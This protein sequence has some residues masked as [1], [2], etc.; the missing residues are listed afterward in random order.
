M[1]ETKS[2]HMVES[3]SE[4]MVETKSE[5]MLCELVSV[6]TS[7]VVKLGMPLAA[8]RVKVRMAIHKNREATTIRYIRCVR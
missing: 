7:A 2:E 4:H 5:R 6:G 1:I 3:E 8:V